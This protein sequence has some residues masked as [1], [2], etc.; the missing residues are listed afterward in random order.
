MSLVTW[1]ETENVLHEYSDDYYLT[2]L[3][4]QSDGDS[5]YAVQTYVKDESANYG[6]EL[7]NDAYSNSQEESEYEY[8]LHMDLY[9]QVDWSAK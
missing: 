6:W 2:I 4:D 7:I 1:E 5:W 9:Y 8:K 3:V